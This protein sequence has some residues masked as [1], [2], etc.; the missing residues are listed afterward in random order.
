MVLYIIVPWDRGA[1]PGR[2]GQLVGE[3]AVRDPFVGARLVLA[4]L[5]HEHDRVSS[6]CTRPSPRRSRKE[7]RRCSHIVP[8]T[9]RRFVAGEHFSE[10]TDAL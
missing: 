2:G 9:H 5:S 1:H 8:S 10:D 7:P 3:M 6:Y 4:R